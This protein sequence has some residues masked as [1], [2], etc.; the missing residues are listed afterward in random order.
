MLIDVLAVRFVNLKSWL[1]FLLLLC[2]IWLQRH[3]MAALLSGI[4]NRCIKGTG[5]SNGGGDL[6]MPMKV[7]QWRMKPI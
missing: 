1:H 6:F 3:K 2:R 7:A 5:Y 4:F